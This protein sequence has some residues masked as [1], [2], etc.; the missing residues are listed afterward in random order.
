MRQRAG[1][2][3]R[4][5]EWPGEGAEFLSSIF[6]DIKSGQ[7]LSGVAAV[8]CSQANHADVQKTSDF[9]FLGFCQF[10]R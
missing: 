9:A 10:T 2:I 1:V 3:R 5:R 6:S 8:D 4:R 7:T